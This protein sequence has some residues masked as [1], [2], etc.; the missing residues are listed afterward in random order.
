MSY[1]IQNTYS[2]AT[3]LKISLRV[4]S[5]FLIRNVNTIYTLTYIQ[6]EPTRILSGLS[7]YRNQILMFSSHF[8][9]RLIPILFP[10]PKFLRFIPFGINFPMTA[11]YQ[12]IVLML[13][14]FK[15]VHPINEFPLISRESYKYPYF[16]R[17]QIAITNISKKPF[18]LALY[19][20]LRLS[21]NLWCL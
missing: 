6:E 14:Q 2:T 19:K 12:A 4:R 8:F 21:L 15:Q 9:T 11:H 20:L 5:S 16:M 18:T 7:S 3:S 13:A 1:L 17:P 10:N